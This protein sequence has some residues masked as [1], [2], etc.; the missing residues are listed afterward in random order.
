MQ[1]LKHTR[2]LLRWFITALLQ[3]P[4]NEVMQQHHKH[5]FNDFEPDVE[6]PNG[7]STQLRLRYP[8]SLQNL[9]NHPLWVSDVLGSSVRIWSVA[10]SSGGSRLK[11]VSSWDI[12]Y[13]NVL[14][15]GS[16]LLWFIMAVLVNERGWQC[17]YWVEKWKRLMHFNFVV[18]VTPL[19]H[20]VYIWKKRTQDRKCT[21][22]AA[23][24]NHDV[25]YAGWLLSD[26]QALSGLCRRICKCTHTVSF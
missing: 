3:L 24:T 1:A 6:P 9:S 13:K 14:W 15:G 25:H 12:L 10:L 11:E 8:S 26:Q 22:I 2:M 20:F 7:I 18:S 17:I 5:S 21:K 4:V 16:D 19:E 23:C